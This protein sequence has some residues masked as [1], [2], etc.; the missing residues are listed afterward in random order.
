MDTQFAN[1]AVMHSDTMHAGVTRPVPGFDVDPMPDDNRL[2]AVRGIVTAVVVAA[3]F[4]ALV[5]FTIYM[6]T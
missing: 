4:W 1:A 2:T 6:L 3:P 5:A